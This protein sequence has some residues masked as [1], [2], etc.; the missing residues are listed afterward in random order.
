MKILE[1]APNIKH[2]IF[3][4]IAKQDTNSFRD[5]VQVYEMYESSLKPCSYHNPVSAK[6]WP[7][8]FVDYF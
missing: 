6:I 7:L 5:N 4:V 1:Y 2:T 8:K 3:G